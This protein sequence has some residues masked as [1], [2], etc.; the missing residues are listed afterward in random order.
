MNEHSG[1]DIKLVLLTLFLGAVLLVVLAIS[2]W[3]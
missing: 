3:K 2:T 1:A